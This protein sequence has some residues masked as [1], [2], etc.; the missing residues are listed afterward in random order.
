MKYLIDTDIGDDIDDALAIGYALRKGL[1]VIGITTVYRNALT[2]ANTAKELVASS[3]KNISVYPGLSAPLSKNV[4]IFGRTNYGNDVVDNHNPEEAIDFIGE[5][6]KKYGKDLCLLI[7]GAQTNLAAAYIK[8]SEYLDQVGQVVIMGGSFNNQCNEW[9]ISEDPTAA[10]IV[11]SSK[12]NLFYVP[13][14]ITAQTG[15][16]EENYERILSYTGDNVLGCVSNMVREWKERNLYKYVPIIH[17]PC[18]LICYLDRNLCK[19]KEIDFAVLDE[20][21]GC[22]L[23]LNISNFD[24]TLLPP[25]ESK[26]ITLVSEIDPNKIIDEFMSVLF[27]E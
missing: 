1:N 9:N 4:K 24:L 10:K 18:A 26:R 25:A 6:A 20:G 22:G 13:F 11:S 14:E 27:K 19:T 15:I 2:R 17:D 8:Y 3:N 21:P 7:I 12:M 5:S 16:G 23:T